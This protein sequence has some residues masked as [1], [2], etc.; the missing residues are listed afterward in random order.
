MFD[1]DAHIPRPNRS[2]IYLGACII[3]GLRLARE[4]SV[5]TRVIPTGMAITESVD[6]A[7][8]IFNKVF[9]KVPPQIQKVH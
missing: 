4:K 9:R 7:H 2:L 3:A 8:E 5:N 1:P 6:L